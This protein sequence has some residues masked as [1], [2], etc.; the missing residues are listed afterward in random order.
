MIKVP[1]VTRLAILVGCQLI[2]IPTF[3]QSLEQAIA[4]T[5]ATNP[6]IQATYNEFISQKETARASVGKYL[7]SVDLE[8]AVGYEDNNSK[9]DDGEDKYPGLNHNQGAASVR[10]HSYN[11][12][13]ASL[14]IRQLLW[15]GS[16]TYHDIKRTKAEA[17]SERY[18]LLA[19]AQDMALST[20]EAYMDVLQAQEVLTLSQTNLDVHNRIYSD[21]KR[22]TDSGLSSTADLIQV[23]GRVAQANTNLISAQN[24]LNDKITAFTRIVGNQP[25]DLKK[26]AVDKTYIA[27]SL[28]DAL[29]KAK[30]N[31]PTMYLAAHDVDAATH[32]YKQNAGTMLPTFTVEASQINGQHNDFTH[33]EKN[34][35]SVM[36]KMNYNLYNGGSDAATT[37][38]MAAQLAKSK[39]VR[40]NA[41]RLLEESTRLSWS[42]KELAE[43]QEKFLQQHVDA[44]AKTIIAYEKQY[45]I[46]QRTLLD[47]LNTE[48]ELFEARKAYLAAHYAGIVAD[49]R[50]LNSTGLLL[51]ELRVAI[52][53]EWAQSSK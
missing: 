48:N 5:L 37:R 49:Y 20:T 35:T 27:K 4:T 7:P 51:N 32:Q 53:D 30:A 43:S 10:P 52:P 1:K 26:P 40:D 31:N 44:S 41:Y 23:E 3:A 39:N 45:K 13:Y 11:P 12:R 28:P 19:D 9:D 8:A 36:L 21:I 34:E 17:E 38:S 24:N 33:D 50:L 16:S 46:G 18:Q 47:L 42:A 6:N 14:T 29:E 22:R 2:A 15:D 25:Q